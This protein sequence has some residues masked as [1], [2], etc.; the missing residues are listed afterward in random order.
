VRAGQVEA[1]IEEAR[2]AVALLDEADAPVARAEALLTLAAA[3]EAAGDPG[4]AGARKRAVAECEAKGYLV[5]VRRARGELDP[6]A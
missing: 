1:G 2:R 4:A 6:V 5:A 3:C